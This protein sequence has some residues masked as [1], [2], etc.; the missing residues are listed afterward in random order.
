MHTTRRLFLSMSGCERDVE[1][2]VEETAE[3]AALSPAAVRLAAMDLLA[4]R[5]HS[6][7]ELRGKLRKRF[8]EESILERQLQRLVEEGLQSDRRFTES[9]LHQ[10]I[11]RGYGP[12]RLRQDLRQRGIED[13]EIGIA[14][15]ALAV[16][17]ETLAKAVHDKKFGA[18]IP[19]DMKEKA[20]RARF[21]QYRGFSLEHFMNLLG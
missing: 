9:F 8:V 4:R 20:R 13:A 14:L 19:G 1:V 18:G 16:D 6:L 2:P 12:L 11:G 10:R 5:E 7:R 15:G 17:W 3:P 21:L